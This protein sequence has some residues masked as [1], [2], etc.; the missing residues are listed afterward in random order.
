MNTQLEID[1]LRDEKTARAILRSKGY[2]TENL[3][4]I[5]DVMQNYHCT[6]EEAFSVLDRAMQNESTIEQIFLAI[7]DVADTLSLRRKDD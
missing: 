4:C 5:D 3:W 6:K 7:D 2:Y 1:N